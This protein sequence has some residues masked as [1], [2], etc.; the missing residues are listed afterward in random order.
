MKCGDRLCQ[1]ALFYSQFPVFLAS[2][3]CPVVLVTPL[4]WAWCILLH[5]FPFLVYVI[6]IFAQ[7]PACSSYQ[8]R[9]T[10]CVVCRATVC[11]CTHCCHTQYLSDL[12][13]GPSYRHLNF[14]GCRLCRVCQIYCNLNSKSVSGLKDGLA[15]DSQVLPKSVLEES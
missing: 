11:F 4:K 12:G 14:R 15:S 2:L 10:M 6:H 3:L 13:S 8:I 5:N 9:R 7:Q 1:H